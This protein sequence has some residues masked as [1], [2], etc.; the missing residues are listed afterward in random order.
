MSNRFHDD[1]D[2]SSLMV[3]FYTRS[4]I[5][6]SILMQLMQLTPIIENRL[7]K[8]SHSLLPH[9]VVLL[10]LETFQSRMKEQNM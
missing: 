4:T 2:S 7:E 9:S 5:N 10:R 3:L 1:A 6:G 8:S